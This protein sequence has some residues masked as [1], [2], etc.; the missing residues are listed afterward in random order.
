MAKLYTNDNDSENIVEEGTMGA[1]LLVR[2]S[3]QSLI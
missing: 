2:E 3:C 1:M